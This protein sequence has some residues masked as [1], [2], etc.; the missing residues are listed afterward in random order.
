MVDFKKY[1]NAY[2]NYLD[3]DDRTISNY[4]NGIDCF[5][6]YLQENNIKTPCRDDLKAFKRAK[7]TA[8]SI[9]TLNYYLT[10]IRGFFRY[11]NKNNV[12]SDITE[13]I[14]NLKTSGNL[15]KQSLTLE[16]TKDIYKNLKN[17]RQRAFFS[18]AITT[19]LRGQEIVDAKIEDIKKYNGEY[20]LFIKGKNRNDKSEYV[21]LAKNV[22]KDINNYIGTRKEGYIF[23]SNSNHNRNGG[24]TTKTLRLEIKNIF[25]ANG[26][27]ENDFSLHSLRRTFATISYSNGGDIYSICQVLHHKSLI[28][29]QKYICQETRNSNML[30]YKISD[31]IFN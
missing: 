20:V 19:G 12:Y 3:I 1:E 6:D 18:L 26:I 11:L 13:D 8:Y 30:E 23:V 31:K 5:L 9:G 14:T 22:L 10:A 4:K 28:T 15:K 21:K 17:D 7:V 29:T 27:E 2:L 16:Q 24:I 25:K